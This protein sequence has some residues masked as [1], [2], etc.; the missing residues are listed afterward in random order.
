[1]SLRIQID[2]GLTWLFFKD[3][4]MEWER[5]QE[6][7][8]GFKLKTEIFRYLQ[9]MH[10]RFA[11]RMGTLRG[12]RTRKLDDPYRLLSAHI[13][14]QSEMALP[15][16]LKP[17]DIVGSKKAQDEFVQLQGECAEYVGDIFWSVFAGSWTAVPVSLRTPLE[18]RFKSKEQKAQ[19][20]G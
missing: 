17:Q 19:F 2:L 11:D 3:H 13:H 5:I 9:E 15:Q 18:Q 7:G 20:F 10:P 16:I 14:G 8:D 6:S 12:V 4:Q 1:M